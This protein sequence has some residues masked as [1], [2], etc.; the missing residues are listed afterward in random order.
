MSEGMIQGYRRVSGP[1]YLSGW[2]TQLS[3]PRIDDR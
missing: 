2:W 1:R 3:K